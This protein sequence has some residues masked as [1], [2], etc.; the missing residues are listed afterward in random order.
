[1]ASVVIL[2]T[3]ALLRNWIGSLVVAE[4]HKSQA[5]ENSSYLAKSSVAQTLAVIIP[6]FILNFLF[7]KREDLHFYFNNFM[8]WSALRELLQG[9]VQPGWIWSELRRW[10][11]YRNSK[12]ED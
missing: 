5:N 3:Q 7:G 1:M 4:K 2:V 12:R 8:L 10:W 11:R 6:L 9:L